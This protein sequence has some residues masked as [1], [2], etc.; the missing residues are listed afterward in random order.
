MKSVMPHLLL[1]L[2]LSTPAGA[3]LPVY[4]GAVRNAALTLSAQEMNPDSVVYVTTD[5]FE[6]VQAFYGR[7]GT[8][9]SG[10]SLAGKDAKRASFA[11]ASNALAAR[12]S[13]TRRSAELGTTITYF[14]PTNEDRA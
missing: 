4:P 13:W 1:Y 7:A 12:I 3:E 6:K 5:E 8:E 2:S 9:V 11:T 10:E 14:S